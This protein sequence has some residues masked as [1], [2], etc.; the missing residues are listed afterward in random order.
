MN[1]TIPASP[2]PAS[3]HAEHQQLKQQLD[4]VTRE[5]GALGEAAREVSRLMKCHF[6]KEERYSLP[7]LTLLPRLAWGTVSDDMTGMLAITKRL[8]AELP[9]MLIEH[10]QIAAA[11]QRLLFEATRLGREDCEA[12]AM[13][14]L[15][16]AQQEEEVHY[17]A[18]VL[19]GEYLALKLGLQ[20]EA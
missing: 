2:I 8:K 6:E 14:L 3:L 11:L 4:H 19:V 9:L 13:A 1:T 17:P 20:Q 12:C 18:A 5:A 16:H 10:K 15:M 7:P